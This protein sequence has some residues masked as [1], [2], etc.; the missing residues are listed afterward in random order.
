[1]NK[2]Q[3]GWFI[4]IAAVDPPFCPTEQA[5]VIDTVK[6]K[7]PVDE[8]LVGYGWTLTEVPGP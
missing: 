8:G 5:E 2:D 4:S 1:M 7:A 6:T 3:T